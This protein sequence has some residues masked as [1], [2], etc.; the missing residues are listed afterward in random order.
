MA[1]PVLGI[2]IGYDTLK[3][4]LVRGGTVLKTAAVPMPKNLL[5]EG[6]ITS[7]DTLGLLIKDTMKKNGIRASRAALSLSNEDCYVRTV[8]MPV[9]SAEQLLINI[10]YEFSDY[11]TDELKNYVFDYAMLSTPEDLRAARDSAGDVPASGIPGDGGEEDGAPTMELMVATVRRSLLDEAREYL[12]RAGLRLTRAAPVMF[13]YAALIRAADHGDGPGEYCILDLGYQSIRMY[14]FKGDRHVVTREL[15]LGLSALDT[16][17][18]DALGVDVHLAHTYL[19]TNYD[20]C[21][22]A[23][24]CQMTYSSIAVELMRAL[25]FYRFS[26]PES[27]LGDVWL[28]GGGA[29]IAPLRDAIGETLDM[30]VHP[31]SE[32]V[33]GGDRTEDRSHFAEAVGIAL[34]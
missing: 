26:N 20:G 3:L 34:E 11:I 21:Q 15:E 14:M 16:A 30:R 4:A 19:L 1:K 12:H 31:A 2:D 27:E 17:I 29:A 32:L 9:M 18:S 28:C 22:S 10:P 8:T 23:E 24:Y 5:K 13:G 33:P 25:N 7:P 6:S